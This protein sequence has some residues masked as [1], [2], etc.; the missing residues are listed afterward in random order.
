MELDKILGIKYPIIQGGMANVTDGKFAATVSEAGALGVIAAGSITGEELIKEIRICKSLTEKPYAVNL[1]LL[2]PKVDELAKIIVEEKVPIVITGA[3]NP[4]KYIEE[5]HK[6]GMKIFPVVPNP[7]L[8]VKMEEQGVDGVIVEG[9]EAGGHIGEMTSMTLILQSKDK[10]KIPVIAAGGIASGKQ[11]L[12]AEVL[13][14]AG[15]QIGTLFLSSLE[16]PIHKEYK[17]LVVNSNFSDVTVIGRSIA[18][19][20]RLLKNQMTIEYLQAEKEGKDKTELDKYTN[21]A[22]KAASE[23][24]DLINGSFMAG[25]T[26]TQI[27]EVRP[28]KEILEGLIDEYKEELEKISNKST[29]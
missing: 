26:V 10:V 17:D 9:N 28:V 2:N 24:G 1:M 14:A 11:I 5:W 27:K 23:S 12:A 4:S 25:L 21:G 6:A 8:A 16:C 18:L 29:K 19:P 15:V 20:K 7:R 3:G 22:L 13:G